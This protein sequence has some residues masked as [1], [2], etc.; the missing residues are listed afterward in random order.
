MDRR[1]FE[2]LDSALAALREGA[3]AVVR[4]GPLEPTQGFREYDPSEQVAA[5]L[6]VSSGGVLSGRT[7]G[8][9]VMGDGTLVPYAGAVRRRPLQGRTPDAALDAVREALA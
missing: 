4:E 2:D 6:A 7:A 8:V 1:D 3:V 5:R 9:D